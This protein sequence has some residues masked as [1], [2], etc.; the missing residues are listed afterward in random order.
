MNSLADSKILRESFPR[1]KRPGISERVLQICTELMKEPTYFKAIHAAGQ[2][3]ALA[4]AANADNYWSEK[5]TIGF[6]DEVWWL[7]HHQAIITKDDKGD[8]TDVKFE[9][10]TPAE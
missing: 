9:K 6:H 3:R 1:F 4:L 7:Q 5:A 2:M 10:L 8:V